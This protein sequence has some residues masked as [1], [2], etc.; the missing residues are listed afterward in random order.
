MCAE[1]PLATEG[2]EVARFLPRRRAVFSKVIK[3][4]SALVGRL[5]LLIF[6]SLVALLVALLAWRY[7]LDR[8][9]ELA[10]FESRAA[11]FGVVAARLVA[12][13]IGE[14]G[15]PWLSPVLDQVAKEEALASLLVF[16]SDGTPLA[17]WIRCSSPRARDPETRARHAVCDAGQE[18]DAMLEFPPRGAAEAF[19]RASLEKALAA[20]GESIAQPDA[21]RASP[22]SWRDGAVFH[23]V[24]QVGPRGALMLAT[25]SARQA[26]DALALRHGL[27]F[28]AAF[29]MVS[30]FS[31][32]LAFVVRSLVKGF[33]AELDASRMQLV[34]SASDVAL[35]RMASGISHEI[36]NPLT[37]VYGK[38][39]NLR[40]QA[41]DASE[42]AD[43]EPMRARVLKDAAKIEQA[44]F[45]I[46]DI[47]NALRIFAEGRREEKVSQSS[48]Q[49]IVQGAL[50]LCEERF[51]HSGISVEL[52]APS[53]PLS[54]RCRPQQMTEVVLNLLHNAHE[55]IVSA[56]PPV[57]VPRVRVRAHASAVG[58]SLRVENNGPPIA[59][60]LAEKIYEPFFSTKGPSQATGLGLAVSRGVVQSHGGRLWHENH[61]G[62]VVFEMILPEKLL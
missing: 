8:R 9:T 48:I 55:A 53:D 50:A 33:L 19:A 27:L 31:S 35:G 18:H 22:V 59:D 39:V 43:C 3:E 7:S 12:I 28:M 38:A 57:D 14:G 32:L 25:F 36:N 41:A 17:A 11:S 20:R 2:E 45:R 60:E 10:A 44:V 23:F 52:I 29:V 42:T 13:A 40:L 61:E 21:A 16:E 34:T 37:V 5:A 47:T 30:A 54:L 46:Y 1:R 49:D 4:P 15:K 51:R 58:I 6:A 26:L 56:S 24:Q 62:L